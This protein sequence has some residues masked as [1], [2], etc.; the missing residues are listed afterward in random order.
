MGMGVPKVK[1]ALACLSRLA[2]NMITITIHAVCM[3]SR[4]FLISFFTNRGN[5]GELDNVLLLLNTEEIL[6]PAE[7]PAFFRSFLCCTGWLGQIM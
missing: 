3:L 5:Q 1:S 6:D 7:I 2:G 4:S